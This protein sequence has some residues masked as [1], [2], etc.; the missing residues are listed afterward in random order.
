M[1]SSAWRHRARFA[2]CTICAGL[3]ASAASPGPAHAQST[4]F[5]HVIFDMPC[6]DLIGTT[7]ED[8]AG[9]N[10]IIAAIFTGFIVGSMDEADAR[11]M[12]DDLFNRSMGLGAFCEIADRSLYD[13][14]SAIVAGHLEA[15]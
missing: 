9:R 6:R 1:A 5:A 12:F 2:L 14:M 3:I 7:E 13:A 8:M 11:A 10:T 4:D 15:R